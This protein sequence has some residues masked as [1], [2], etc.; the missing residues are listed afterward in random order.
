MK[1]VFLVWYSMK[2]YHQEI[3]FTV[4]SS[5]AISNALLCLKDS[6]IQDQLLARMQVLFFFLILNSV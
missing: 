2:F 4:S 5:R 3:C 6:E 1:N